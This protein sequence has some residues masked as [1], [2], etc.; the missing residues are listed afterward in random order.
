MEMVSFSSPTINS[1]QP[2][3][4]PPSTNQEF[5][6]GPWAVLKA[7]HS[8]QAYGSLGK[9]SAAP[10][11]TGAPSPQLPLD[12]AIAREKRKGGL[13]TNANSRK[14]KARVS[15]SEEEWRVASD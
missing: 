6:F 11:A 2:P 14:S 9:A 3:E 4:A 8:Q 5:P 12:H 15:V 7:G 1:K 13:K 10:P